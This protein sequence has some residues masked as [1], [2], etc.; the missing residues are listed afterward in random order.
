VG[1][2]TNCGSNI[3][4]GARFCTSC[5]NQASQAIAVATR[6]ETVDISPSPSPTWYVTYATG[7]TGGPFTEDE[8]RGMIA[9]QEIKITDSIAA[10]GANTWVPITQ[11][12]FAP[13][14]VSQASMDRLAASTCPRC[15]AAMAVVLR[16]SS[17]ATILII[18]GIVTS[19]AIIGIPFIII[20]VIMARKP[21]AAYQCPRCNYKTR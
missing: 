13:F 9:R 19:W 4:E 14:V 7:Q 6:G 17:M 5:G 21:T 10:R 1:F 16:R 12:P 20:G 8:V 2:C 15:G 3:A 11:S 18:G